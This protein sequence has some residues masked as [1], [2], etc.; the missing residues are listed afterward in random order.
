MKWDLLTYQIYSDKQDLCRYSAHSKYKR[1][2][3]IL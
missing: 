2:N 3:K 1:N